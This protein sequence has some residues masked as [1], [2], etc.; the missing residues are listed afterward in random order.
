MTRGGAAEGNSFPNVHQELKCCGFFHWMKNRIYLFFS[1]SVFL[2]VASVFVCHFHIQWLPLACFLSGLLLRIVFKSR[3]LEIFTFLVPILPFF[4]DFENRGFPLNYL[5]LP[6]F[7]LAGIVAGELVVNRGRFSPPLPS[8]PRFYPF[9]L[10]LLGT[11]FFFVMLRW[12]NFT[13]SPLA[14]FKNTPVA[15][16]GQRLSFGIVFPVVELA[17]FAISP[18]YFLLLK[19]RHD[20]KRLIIAF[21]SGQSVSVLNT[22]LQ[23]RQDHGNVPLPVNGLASDAT[24]FGFLSALAL[25]LAWYLFSRYSEKWLGF[26]FAG[27]SLFGIVRSSTR[28]CLLAIL[29]VFL[30]FVWANRKK[31]LL[32]ILL[33][34]SLLV[35]SYL[36][37]NLVRK[38]DSKIL[39]EIK[40]NVRIT[41]RFLRQNG[42]KPN[43]LSTIFSGRD[44]L[45]KYSIEC[46]KEFPLSGVGP[47]NFIFWVMTAHRDKFFHH[48]PANQYLFIA[49]STGLIGLL[50]FILFCYGLFRRKEWNEKWLLATFLILLI[51]NDYLWFSEIFLVFWLFAALGKKPEGHPSNS[52]KRGKAFYA[53]IFSLFLIFNL[54]KFSKLH[55]LAWA[56]KA[57]AA[58]NYGFSYP[59]KEGG[60][61]FRWSDKKA[62]VYV[63][64]GKDNP[65]PEFNLICGAPI[66]RLPGKQQTVDVYW[67]G[68]FLTQVVFRKNGEMPLWINDKSH[69]EGFLEFR[70]RPSFNLNEMGIGDESRNMGIQVSGRGISDKPSVFTLNFAYHRGP[71]TIRPV[72]LNK[73]VF[74]LRVFKIRGEYSFSLSAKLEEQAIIVTPKKRDKNGEMLILFG[75]QPNESTNNIKVEPGGTII[76]RA[77]V[78]LSNPENKMARLVIQEKMKIW[79]I[80][81]IAIDKS[82][83]QQYSIEKRISG[84]ADIIRCGILWEPQTQDEKLEIREFQIILN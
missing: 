13:L 36:F 73:T 32:L 15:P 59:E 8:L 58:Y 42:V 79:E 46:L 41:D 50:A 44:I 16:T 40:K 2:L 20:L 35:A 55:P 6:L 57:G 5:F 3:Y 17:L 83:W 66:S 12:S 27:I 80:E 33:G 24:S 75:I 4:A 60:R 1:Y 22:L 69:G 38:S 62:G 84:N 23:N 11:S 19:R 10:L 61:S 21:L 54:L 53:G 30:L 7:F 74:P 70:V 67:R 43:I 34:I 76:F 51:F 39:I 25:L 78:R 29:V 48:L 52:S 63:F 28:V 14:F 82:G 64:L 49:T 68:K 81:S 18:L 26:V 47:G 9:F 31:Y 37:V 77:I 65:N 45:W 72:D 56:R 71:K